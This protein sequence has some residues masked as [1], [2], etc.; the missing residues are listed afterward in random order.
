MQIRWNIFFAVGMA[1]L[2]SVANGEIIYYT[3]L[4]NPPTQ[5]IFEN[6]HVTAFDLLSPLKRCAVKSKF[7]CFN[8][9]GLK[10]AIPKNPAEQ[11]RWSYDGVTY[12]R[13]KM[14]KMGVLG[15]EVTVYFIQQQ[16]KNGTLEF[17][18]SMERGLLAF[19]GVFEKPK[20]FFLENDCGFGSP[21]DCNL[22]ARQDGASQ[23]RHP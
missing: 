13:K 15:Q 7:I 1:C 12:T 3:D 10:F 16:G 8:A 14:Q 18:Y 11:Q 17:I 23:R 6:N 5:I 20:F 21:S 2:S 9:N 19:G 22:K 4:F